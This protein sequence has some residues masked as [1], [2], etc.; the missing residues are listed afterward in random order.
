MKP[1]RGR[2]TERLES[3]LSNKAF[4]R[5]VAGDLKSKIKED[6]R[7]IEQQM[8]PRALEMEIDTSDF[9]EHLV[10]QFP[11]DQKKMFKRFLEIEN[12]N[13]E[14]VQFELDHIS[15][16]GFW[17]GFE[18]IDLVK[19]RYEKEKAEQ[20]DFLQVR[21][22][23]TGEDQFVV[24]AIECILRLRLYI[25]MNIAG[26]VAP[27]QVVFEITLDFGLG[28][29]PVLIGPLKEVIHTATVG[30]SHILKVPVGAEYVKMCQATL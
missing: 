20:F 30:E 3:I 16:T 23:S 25:E 21:W 6:T 29:M 12:N 9:Y 11:S 5:K 15:K 28:K 18:E 24:G 19:K 27:V 13:I 4:I 26:D 1:L 8:L 22:P 7:G 10:E 2:S 14:V 17:F